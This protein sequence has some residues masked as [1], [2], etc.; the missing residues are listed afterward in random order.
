LVNEP[1]LTR[2]VTCA[3]DRTVRFWHFVDSAAVPAASRAKVQKG[4]SRNAYC[5]DMSRILFVQNSEELK[6]S[7][8]E[9]FKAKPQDRNEEGQPVTA[10]ADGEADEVLIRRSQD[11]EQ[12]IRC[13]RLSPDGRHLA[14][15]DWHGN[16]RIHNLEHPNLEE[17]KC[18]EA[19]E[20]EVLSLD[21]VLQEAPSSLLESSAEAGP[22]YLLASGSRDRL[23]QVYDSR[24]DYE[25]VQIIETHGGTV[26][27]VRFTQE[28][29]SAPDARPLLSL[30]SGG[31]DKKL[32]KH[33][34]GPGKKLQ[35]LEPFEL[36]AQELF[37]NKIFS[38]DIAPRGE[39][40]LT[41]HDKNLTLSS[42]RTLQKIW[43]KRP[44][45]S[46]KVAPDH[47]KV[48][49]DEQGAVAV[50]SCTDKQLLLFD[51]ETGKLLCK[52]QCGEITTGMCFTRGKRHLVTTSS[53]GVIY[54]WKLPEAV[55]KAL[56]RHQ[57]RR[58]GKQSSLLDRIEEEE[59][60]DSVQ[61]PAG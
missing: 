39:L 35:D 11:I 52:A 42:S 50:T 31:A 28:P 38:M 21:Y 4:L 22:G 24:T 2:F 57:A 60:E 55:Q 26:T 45:P 16:V 23:I 37:K 44:D 3:S 29:A 54:I 32:L 49:L 25:P 17:V 14:C 30:L 1:G 7:D 53:L 46:R 10:E 34:F 8:Y 5:K 48:M 61:R 59:L 36:A 56:T 9:V 12:A 20:N 27:S 40:V 43:Q 58:I 19:H 18:I 15:G 47:L 51:V 13:L 41:G 33:S 6:A